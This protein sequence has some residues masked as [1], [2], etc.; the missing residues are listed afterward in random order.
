MRGAFFFLIFLFAAVCVSANAQ[1]KLPRFVC[2]KSNQANLRVGPGERFPIDWVFKKK[3]WPFEVTDEYEHWR[4][5]TD[6]DGTTGWIHKSML[7][8]SPRTALTRRD[9]KTLFYKKDDSSS[10]IIAIL[11]GSIPV[12]IK[13]AKKKVL[14]AKC[15]SMT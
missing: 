14:S 9:E 15:L 10:R 5:V 7:A 6:I 8:S 11:K 12:R 13:N 1:E 2:L 4:K 3:G